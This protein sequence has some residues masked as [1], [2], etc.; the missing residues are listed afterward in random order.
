MK[1]ETRL[2]GD[3]WNVLNFITKTLEK[4]INNPNKHAN[5]NFNVEFLTNNCDKNR[6]L[7]SLKK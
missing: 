4:V 3:I 1:K 2:K 6:T 5:K 7:G